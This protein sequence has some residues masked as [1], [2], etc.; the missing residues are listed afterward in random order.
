MRRQKLQDRLEPKQEPLKTLQQRIVKF[1]RNSRALANTRFEGAIELMCKLSDTKLIRKPQ[2]RHEKKATR[3]REPRGLIK[4]R[5]NRKLQQCA[6]FVPDAAVV[7]GDDAET[8]CA[9]SE[10]RIVR[11]TRIRWHSPV[12]V[13]PL[14]LDA[15]LD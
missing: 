9:W 3:D 2:Q 10:V 11:V 5:R 8:V 4:R 7:R 13:L 12:I 15:H 14:Q 1:A 6:L